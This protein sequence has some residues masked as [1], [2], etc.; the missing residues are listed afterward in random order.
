MKGY[1]TIGAVSK[2]KG[3]SIKSLRYYD[4]IGVLRPAYINKM[5]N[6]RY[7]TEEQLYILDAISLCIELGIPLRDFEKYTDDQGNFNLQNL[8][9]DGKLLAEQKIMD[10]RKR[11]GTVQAALQALDYKPVPLWTDTAQDT[12]SAKAQHT[13]SQKNTVTSSQNDKDA[14]LSQTVITADQTEVSSAQ[15]ATSIPEPDEKADFYERYIPARAVL[16]TPFT[17]EDTENYS[18]KILRLFM[19]AQLLGMTA[20]YPSGILYEYDEEGNV[21]KF[22]FVHVEN[23]EDCTDKRLHILPAG[24][25]SCRQGTRHTI[26]EAAHL[27]DI[28]RLSGKPFTIVESDLIDNK[29]KKGDNS[30]ELQIIQN[31]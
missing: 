18:Q 1:L 8:L 19:L 20:N 25:Y 29:I 16:T 12:G 23:Y 2:K 17:E 31:K 22:I 15:T 11:L 30:L 7:Y 9:Y 3:V 24:T 14:P 4:R 10:I 28:F 6:Y 21:Q 13:E 27:R 26:T 5:T